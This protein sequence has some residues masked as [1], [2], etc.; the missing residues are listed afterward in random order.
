MRAV[1]PHA[2]RHAVLAFLASQSPRCLCLR[3]NMMAE[4]VSNRRMLLGS[5]LVD[6]TQRWLATRLQGSNFV[7][8]I[9]HTLIGVKVC[10]LMYDS[11]LVFPYKCDFY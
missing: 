6:H 10:N 11:S 1:R 4:K 8:H 9:S 5:N 2:V 7:Y 3:G